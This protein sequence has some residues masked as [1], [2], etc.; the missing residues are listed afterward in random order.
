MYTFTYQKRLLHTLLLLVFKIV[1]S[2]QCALN[3]EVL[4]GSILGATLFLLCINDYSDVFVTCNIAIYADDTTLYSRCDQES[5][6][7][8]QLQL[9]SE[10]KSDL[11]DA[12]NW[13]RKRFIDF[14][15]GKTELFWFDCSNNS[16]AI[17]VKMDGCA[18]ERKII[19]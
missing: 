10:L 14:N 8:Q 11:Q 17:V 9:G 18:L 2:L 19:F 15:A 12:I 3:A 13:C 7:W 1:K 16:T 4:Q 5:S 6:L